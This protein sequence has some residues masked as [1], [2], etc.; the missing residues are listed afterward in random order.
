MRAQQQEFERK[1]AQ[2]EQEKQQ[3]Q[4]SILGMDTRDDHNNEQLRQYRQRFDE[5]NKRIQDQDKQ[6]EQIKTPREKLDPIWEQSHDKSSWNIDLK[7]PTDEL[8]QEAITALVTTPT[9]AIGATTII[10]KAI[11]TWIDDN[12]INGGNISE[13]NLVDG[14][15]VADWGVRARNKSAERNKNNRTTK[16]QDVANS[17]NEQNNYTLMSMI[18]KNILSP[19]SDSTPE[20]DV[21]DLND[22]RFQNHGGQDPDD[23][24]DDDNDPDPRAQDR[25]CPKGYGEEDVGKQFRRVNPRNIIIITFIGKPITDQSLY[26]V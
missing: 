21:G 6:I 9:Y 26:K 13:R 17:S 18:E 15:I 8:V 14:H 11:D 10:M 7:I 12:T 1:Q 4:R 20:R 24:D 5:K 23:D 16:S 19:D 3:L 22:L 25:R 2:M